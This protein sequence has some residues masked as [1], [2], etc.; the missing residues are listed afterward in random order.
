M[1]QVING[2]VREP[3]LLY[4]AGS[5]TEMARVREFQR[6]AVAAGW[7][8]THDWTAV[9]EGQGD[10]NPVDATP[11][12]C[13]AWADADLRGV[14]EADIVV[15]LLPRDGS[16]SRGTYFEF[17]FATGIGKE[18][19]TVATPACVSIFNA[20]AVRGCAEDADALALLARY[21]REGL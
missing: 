1:R 21:A 11:E 2:H 19:I 4:V 5:S 8:I 10:G 20:K 12:Q 16:K 15:F 9:V 14:R 18:T 7:K 6:L 3:D 13:E 17:G